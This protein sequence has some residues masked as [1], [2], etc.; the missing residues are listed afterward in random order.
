S[1]RLPS[2]T[3]PAKRNTAESSVIARLLLLEAE[4]AEAE[5]VHGELFV[6][7]LAG[8]AADLAEEVFLEADLGEVDPLAFRR[9]VEVAR[10]DLRL[11]DE[12]DA[13]VAE[14]GEAY[15]IPGGFFGG[16]LA[17]ELEL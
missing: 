17:G 15:G 7:R 14:I 2:T 8:A 4:L 3:S 11:G 5:R 13:A 16:F 12:G 9:P 1:A 10:R 6:E